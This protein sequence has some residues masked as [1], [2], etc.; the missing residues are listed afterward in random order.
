VAETAFV[1]HTGLLLYL[2]EQLP[3]GGTLLMCGASGFLLL[4]IRAMI[5]VS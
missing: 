4:F 5:R 3:F 2:S 1:L